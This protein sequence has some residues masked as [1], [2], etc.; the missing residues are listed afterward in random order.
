[1]ALIASPLHADEQYGLEPCN[2]AL[3][4][5]ISLTEAQKAEIITLK[6]EVKYLEDKI[7]EP[8]PAL[9]P[10]WAFVALGAL[11]GVLTYKAVAK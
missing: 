4:A 1:M 6:T 11:G 3:N 10:W 2:R 9:L 5:C 8:T 7:A